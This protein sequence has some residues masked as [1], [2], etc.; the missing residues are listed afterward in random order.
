MQQIRLRQQQRGATMLGTLVIVAILGLGLYGVIRLTPVYL[1]Y[2]E[3]V[4]AME[5]VAK[6]NKAEDTNPAQIRSALE[7]H[8]EIEDIKSLDVK[9]IEVRKVGSGYEMH[10]QYEGRTPFVANIFWAIAF[11]KT[12]MLN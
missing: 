4:R 5:S 10:A 8:W 7:K 12:V 1:E 9:D 3:I 2:F 11:D 6:E